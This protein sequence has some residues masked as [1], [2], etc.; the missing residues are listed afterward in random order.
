[1]DEN[2]MNE[3]NNQT[4]QNDPYGNTMPPEIPIP[5]MKWGNPDTA[6]HATESEED[7]GV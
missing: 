1:M 7:N 6:V 5:D 2:R 4:G 3:Q